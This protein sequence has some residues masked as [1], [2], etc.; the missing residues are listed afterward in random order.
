MEKERGP[1]EM[2][3]L[4]CKDLQGWGD[5][6][7]SW[8]EKQQR[9]RTRSW[10]SSHK[11]TSLQGTII[12][13]CLHLLYHCLCC[14]HPKSLGQGK[15]MAIEASVPIAAS[16]S[17]PC[18]TVFCQDCKTDTGTMYPGR[19]PQPSLQHSMMPS[20]TAQGTIKWLSRQPTLY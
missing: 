1:K 16:H 19:S 10:W 9:G 20:C 14:L 18:S 5:E 13:I 7:H 3:R 17:V 12:W 11:G 2:Y 15:A 8:L 4:K 6:K